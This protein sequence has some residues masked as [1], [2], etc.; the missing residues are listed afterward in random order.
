MK[1]NLQ[2]YRYLRFL[3]ILFIEAVI[4]FYYNNNTCDT[5]KTLSSFFWEILFGQN[6]NFKG[7]YALSSKPLEMRWHQSSSF[8]DESVR[9][10]GVL[11]HGLT[12]TLS[13]NLGCVL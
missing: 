7:F 3:F 5:G 11:R 2:M 4:F 12:C 13:L 1:H 10:I 6:S 8:R 9:G